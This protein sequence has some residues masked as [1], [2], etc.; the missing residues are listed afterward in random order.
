MA[1]SAVSKET[2]VAESALGQPVLPQ[3]Q[4]V[5]TLVT[6]TL[7]DGRY[8]RGDF[9]SRDA[10]ATSLTSFQIDASRWG[11]GLANSVADLH[12]ELEQE[13]STLLEGK[14]LRRERSAARQQLRREKRN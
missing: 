10:L 3:Q 11:S 9:P 14:Q 7:P 1:E 2:K 6:G 8:G 5:P 13:E 4:D 12:L